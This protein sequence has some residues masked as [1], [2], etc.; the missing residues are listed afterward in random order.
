MKDLAKALLELTGIPRAASEVEMQS[1][2][3]SRG[4]ISR[5]R[6]HSYILPEATPLTDEQV[7]SL[8][9]ANRYSA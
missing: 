4:T 6:R 9:V 3:I 2:P 8:P 1:V 5:R 7:R